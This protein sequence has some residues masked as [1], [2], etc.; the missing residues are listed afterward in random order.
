MFNLKE[1]HFFSTGTGSKLKTF[2]GVQLVPVLVMLSRHSEYADK[3]KINSS[4]H[5]IID[6]GS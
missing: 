5:V 1:I 2:S 4:C 3:Q 6:K